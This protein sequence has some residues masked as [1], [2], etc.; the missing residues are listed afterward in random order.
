MSNSKFT[1]FLLS[2][3]VILFI[4]L[5]ALFFVYVYNDYKEAEE[6]TEIIDISEAKGEIKPVKISENTESKEL[7][8]EPIVIPV[9]K[10]SNTE[11]TVNKFYYN[12]LDEYSK[13][14]Y[15]SLE[16]QKEKLKTGN[17]RINLPDKTGEVLGNEDSASAIFS[18]AINAFECDN[19]DIFYLDAS[20]LVLFYERDS[21]GT[22]NIYLKNDEQQSNYL[23]QDFNNENDIEQAKQKIEFVVQEINAEVEK[24]N[25]DNNKVLYIHDWLVDN[26]KYDQTLSKTNRDNIYGAFV[27]K[28]VT[29]G[30][31]AKAFKYLIDKLNINCIIIQGEATSESGTENHAWNYIEL[32]NKWYG[33]DCTWDD[34]I[35]IGGNSIPREKYYTY[36]LKGQNV[37]NNDHKPFETF[38]GTDLKLNYPEL[39]TGDY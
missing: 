25:G 32:N 37:F 19:P 26:I 35:I 34:P 4:V 29:C 18:I 3:I 22:Y 24:I 31:Y 8:I 20:K 6:T 27:E 1:T 39:E 17:A 12:Q 28:E 7:K 23:E 14:I 10:D 30:G 21:K 11:K 16:E 33:I 15:E 2:T 36:Y 38:F 5:F 13:L 9:Q